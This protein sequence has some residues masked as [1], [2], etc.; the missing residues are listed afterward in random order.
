MP[1][2][3]SQ[4]PYDPNPPE[5][6]EV[7]GAPQFSVRATPDDFGHQVGVAVEKAGEQGQK[8]GNEKSEM[9]IQFAK[10]STEAKVNDDF[11]NQY[12]P[13]AALL[14]NKYDMLSPQE[15]VGGYSEYINGLHALNDRFTASQPSEYGQKAMSGLIDRHI[16]GE[17]DGANRELVKSQIEFSGQAVVDLVKAN[18]T[19]AS[20]NY[21]NPQLVQNV[22]DQNDAH[23]QLQYMN[24]GYPHS[25]PVIQQAQSAAKGQ[26]AGG[27]ISS[28]VNRGDAQE[29][30]KI[31]AAF[32]TFLPGYSQL[33]IDNLLHGENMK[34][35]G[36][37]GVNAMIAGQ[38][39]PEPVGAP[40]TEIQAQVADSAQA[41]GVDPNKAL[42]FLRI[43]TADGK[44]LGT[45]G[46]LFQTP[47]H[48]TP[49]EQIKDGLDGMKQAETAANNAVGGQAEPWQQYVCF[50]QGAT[51]GAAL[52]KADRNTKAVD[53]IAPF[54]DNPKDALSAVTQNGGNATM[55]TGDFLDFLKSKYEAN[56]A[57]AQINVPDGKS[58]GD[59]IRAPHTETTAAVQTGATPRQSLMEFDK[60]APEIL[61]RIANVPNTDVR[62]A[63]YR[64]FE[65]KRSVVKAAS[66][67]YSR[68]LVDGATQL[69]SKPDFTGMDQV[70]P[71]MAAA[72][73][74]DAP[75][76]IGVM[77]HRAEY[78]LKNASNLVDADKTSYGSGFFRAMDRIAL[79][80]NDPHSV[81]DVQD[82]A[83]N[84]AKGGDLTIAGFDKL[85]SMLDLKKT[86][87]GQAEL[88]GIKT[89]LAY[90]RRQI[91]GGATAIF[92]QDPKGEERYRQWTAMF[93][94]DYDKQ[95]AAGKSPGSLLSP[96]SSDYL[97][98]S[99]LGFTR[100][101]TERMKDMEL[102]RQVPASA[103]PDNRDI[104][105]LRSNPHKA[106]LFDKKYGHGAAEEYLAQ[107]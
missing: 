79:P 6:G 91:M 49:E 13:A 35:T 67:A 105:Y 57:R 19:Y 52:L 21:N 20:A 87:E 65:Q 82:F 95:K 81:N 107:R 89:M 26:M 83:P 23:I 47:K 71:E 40:L 93:L 102:A 16:V 4:V 3:S 62:Q 1:N 88:T 36:V 85:N 66:D 12:A 56:S 11:A 68:N 55:S 72:V 59:A 8:V 18:N 53:A 25:D 27:M 54:Y 42:T 17:I 60:K 15:K 75:N 30:N 31:R 7:G 48:G 69:M 101:N 64:Y 28:A 73:A 24:Q 58:P 41:S 14:R 90:G 51:G 80:P 46:T 77:E 97:G 61:D 86:P 63:A 38:P 10:M 45:R 32:S 34:Q 22:A 70:P 96:D 94:S 100:T 84:A 37:N 92:A 50:Q 29:A 43:E 99:V 103:T 33:Q 5:N 76:L 78:N 9:E 74:Q 2:R 106:Q 104:E 39:L 98:K 44:I